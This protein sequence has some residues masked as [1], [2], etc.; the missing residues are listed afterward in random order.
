MTTTISPRQQLEDKLEQLEADICQ[1]ATTGPSQLQA[2]TGQTTPLEVSFISCDIV[3]L[4][5]RNHSSDDATPWDSRS[6]QVVKSPRTTRS[7]FEGTL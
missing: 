5:A 3:G 1:T 7:K 6:F 2:D 4:H